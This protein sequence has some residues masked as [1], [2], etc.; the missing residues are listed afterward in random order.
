LPESY[1]GE[2]TLR[3]AVYRRIA[4]ARVEEEFVALRQEFVD[5]FGPAPVQLEH[6]LLHQRIRR[7]AEAA[8]VTRVRRTAA[9]YELSFD[10]D[11]PGAHPAAMALLAAVEGATLTPAQVV[12]LP[13]PGRDPAGGAAELMVLLRAPR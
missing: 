12:R 7:L 9:G 3:L 1:V 5:R 2:E 6:L 4:A 10:P 11:H 13:M 8:G